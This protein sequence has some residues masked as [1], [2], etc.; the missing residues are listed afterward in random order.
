MTTPTRA[1]L[2]GAYRPD[3]RAAP[4]LRMNFI[5]SADGA[6]TVDGRSGGL[7]G[8][9]DRTLMQVLRAMSDVIMVGA[10]T[11]RAEVYGGTRVTGADAAWRASHG[12]SAQPLLAVVSRTLDL[13][14]ECPFFADAVNRPLVVTCA[15]A[16]AERRGALE[17]VAD[18]FVSGVDTVDLTAMRERLTE[19]G[20]RHVL[21]EGGPHLFG[22]LWEADLVDE[23]CLT[24][25]PRLIGGGAGRILR[26]TREQSRRLRL[27]HSLVDDEGFL[28]LRYRS[29]EGD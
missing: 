19:R 1:E 21:C 6:A 24:I 28:L 29:V 26:G 22:A 5:A 20:L 15:S 18:V 25:A 12:L 17:E 7:G 4:I 13:D 14:P 11:V 27:V 3:D 16:P 8:D 2:Y 9:T 10:G 23:L